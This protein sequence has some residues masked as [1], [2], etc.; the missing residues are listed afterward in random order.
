MNENLNGSP[1]PT[2]TL[3]FKGFALKLKVRISN[4]PSSVQ[5]A[6]PQK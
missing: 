5:G 4:V 6:D 2:G 3:L 1:S